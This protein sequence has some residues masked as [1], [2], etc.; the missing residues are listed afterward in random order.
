MQRTLLLLF[1]ALLFE[2]CSSIHLENTPLQAGEA[3]PERR[4]IAPVAR[5]Y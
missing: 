2:A 5:R 4:S 3:N 1:C